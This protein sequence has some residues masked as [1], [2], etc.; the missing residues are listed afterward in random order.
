MTI[1]E[2]ETVEEHAWRAIHGE[3]DVLIRQES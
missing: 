3:E 2:K 1:K